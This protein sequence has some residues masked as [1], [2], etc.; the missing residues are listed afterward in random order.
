MGQ[1]NKITLNLESAFFPESFQS[2]TILGIKAVPLAI[3]VFLMI[4]HCQYYRADCPEVIQGEFQL[5]VA[6]VNRYCVH[7]HPPFQETISQNH[8]G[9]KEVKG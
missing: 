1:I 3:G 2:V 8:G 6:V 9:R 7:I 5:L 4:V